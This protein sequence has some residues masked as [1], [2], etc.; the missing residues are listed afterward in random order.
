MRLPRCRLPADQSTAAGVAAA[1][2]TDW[3]RP[4]DSAATDLCQASTSYSVDCGRS[5]SRSTQW[6]HR[7]TDTGIALAEAGD[8]D[9][10]REDMQNAMAKYLPESDKKRVLGVHAHCIA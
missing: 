10:D 8:Y 6:R 7:A 1:A 5:S 4:I 3:E 2:S 9:A